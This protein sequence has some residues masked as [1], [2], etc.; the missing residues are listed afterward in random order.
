MADIH[1]KYNL[2]LADPVGSLLRAFQAYEDLATSLKGSEKNAEARKAADEIVS[3]MLASDVGQSSAKQTAVDF[4]AYMENWSPDLREQPSFW[5][6]LYEALSEVTRKVKAMRD[7]YVEAEL[8]RQGKAVTVDVSSGIEECAALKR[9]VELYFPLLVMNGINDES[10]LDLPVYVSTGKKG[11]RSAD[12]KPEI[13]RDVLARGVTVD[14]ISLALKRMP[15]GP[16]SV[17]AAKPEANGNAK[18]DVSQKRVYSVDGERVE[19][20]LSKI[21]AEHLSNGG[22]NP[23]TREDIVKAC[24]HFKDERGFATINGRELAWWRENA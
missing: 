22:A 21:A 14:K 17:S 7:N 5:A 18:I 9:E 16:R 19:G 3:A 23:V 15:T 12:E 20:E 10:F 6:H 24:G 1:S 4:Q 2:S 8:A 11:S 13:L